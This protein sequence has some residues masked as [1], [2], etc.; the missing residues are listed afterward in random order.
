VFATHLS[1]REILN[2]IR[3]G[4]VYVLNR[5]QLDIVILV[6]GN[7][8]LPGSDLTEAVNAAE[9]GVI[10]FRLNLSGIE[11][12]KLCWIEN[13]KQIKSVEFDGGGMFEASFDWKGTDYAWARAEIRS[14]DGVLMGFTNP[15]S[16]GA[17]V[18]EVRT[19]EQAVIKAGFPMIDLKQLNSLGW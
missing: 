4:H 6:D 3:A 9:D 11:K 7:P 2:G 17:R 15:V 1:A 13:G 18:P 5:G 16:Y 14:V 12:G 10:Y 8:Y 19:W